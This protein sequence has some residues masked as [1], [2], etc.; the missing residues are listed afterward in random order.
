MHEDCLLK[1]A[2][3]KAWARLNGKQPMSSND[4]IEFNGSEQLEDTIQVDPM[5]SGIIA[6]TSLDSVRKPSSMK[7]K[8]RRKT[9][10]KKGESNEPEWEGQLE[11]RLETKS[12]PVDKEENAEITGN[13]IFKDKRSKKEPRTW[14]KRLACLFCG[15]P[16]S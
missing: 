6:T 3:D 1:D 7:G 2:T 16:L 8:S 11:A 10:A 9:K 15:N 5:A 14:N 12:L 13:V 4:T